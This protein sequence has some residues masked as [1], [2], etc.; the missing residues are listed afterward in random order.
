LSFTLEEIKNMSPLSRNIDA[1]S[2]IAITGFFLLTILIFVDVQSNNSITG[3]IF[4]AST[5]NPGSIRRK[6]AQGLLTRAVN[7]YT[8]RQYTEALPLFE[9]ALEKTGQDSKPASNSGQSG[10]GNP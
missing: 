1:K 5:F 10:C 2:A 8:R 9:E 7:A 4:P 6:E 3:R